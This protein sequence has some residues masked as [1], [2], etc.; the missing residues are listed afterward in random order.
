MAA[1]R[2]IFRVLLTLLLAAPAVAAPVPVTTC[3]QVVERGTV[4]VLTGD[5]ACGIKWGTCRQCATC[6]DYLDPAVA[7]S[8]P[9]DCP[10]P[11]VNICDGGGGFSVA[12]FVVPG[13][14]LELNGHTIGGAQIGVFGGRPDFVIPRGTLRIVGPGTITATREAVRGFRATVTGVSLHENLYG[15]AVSKLRLSDV[16]AS[17]NTIGVSVFDSLRATRLTSDGNRNIGVLA[18]ER[19]R[20]SSSHVTASGGVDIAS[21]LRPRVTAT[22]CD[23]S[24]ALEETSEPGVYEPTGPPWGVCAGD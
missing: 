21:E 24:A 18:Y 6:P 2:G 12:V 5:L 19:A 8:A 13:A 15:I 1:L 16:D 14:R 10:D 22:T 7:C 17:G 20:L 3:G 9:A 23:R 11:S 4:G